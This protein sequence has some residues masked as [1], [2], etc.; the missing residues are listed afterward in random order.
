MAVCLRHP[1]DKV[2]FAW[3]AIGY[4]VIT[5]F[6]LGAGLMGWRRIITAE[7]LDAWFET[8]KEAPWSLGGGEVAWSGV[9]I[10]LF[11]IVVPLRPR[12]HLLG[13][14]LSIAALVAWP[15]LSLAVYPVP[16]ELGARVDT[17]TLAV[18][19]QLVFG[20]LLCLGI[21]YWAARQSQNLTPGGLLG[22]SVPTPWSISSAPAAWA[23]S[24]SP[25][26]ACWRARPR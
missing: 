25:S 22:S 20:A 12:L 11:A 5:A 24:G 19:A 2:W 17:V 15:L 6:L 14:V 3:V 18:I 21:G 16:A 1:P 23:R 4:E 9:W 13:G 8:R 7:V 26:T 10:L